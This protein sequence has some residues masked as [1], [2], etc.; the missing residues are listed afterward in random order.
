MTEN[1]DRSYSKAEQAPLA[2]CATCAHARG[3]HEGDRACLASWEMG[4]GNEPVGR[5]TCG[6]GEYWPM[7][8]QRE[9]G[10]PVVEW[11]VSFGGAVEMWLNR[12]VTT[13]LWESLRSG[14]RLPLTVSVAVEQK[15]FR[16]LHSKGGLLEVRRVKVVEVDEET[17]GVDEET[18]ELR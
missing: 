6:C 3:E 13:E 7:R 15:G 9:D 18:G 12:R 8:D 4:G 1:E 5:Q 16:M 17:L 11:A 14:A 10:I 2:L